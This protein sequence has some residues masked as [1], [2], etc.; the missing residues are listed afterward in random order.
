MSGKLAIWFRQLPGE[1]DR[2]FSKS[3]VNRVYNGA[4]VDLTFNESF[5]VQKHCDYI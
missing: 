5:D 2:C 1:P 4:V 3:E